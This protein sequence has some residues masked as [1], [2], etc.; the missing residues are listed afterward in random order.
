MWDLR[1]RQLRATVKAFD[2]AS[3]RS[4][5]SYPGSNL[6]VTGSS[7]GDIKVSYMTFA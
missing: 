2:S 5:Y 4:M 7:E 6:L 1:Q 3:V